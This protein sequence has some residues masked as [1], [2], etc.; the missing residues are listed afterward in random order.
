MSKGLEFDP[1]RHRYTLDGKPIPG[2]TTILGKGL[3]KPGLPYWSANVVA[4]Y[5][6]D[7]PGASYDELRRSPWAERD[8]A[9]VRGTEV[10]AYSEK[11][12]HGDEVDVPAT[13]APY[14][15]GAVD[16]MDDLG[17]EPIHTEVQLA[18]RAHW[19]AGTADLFARV[20]DE[21]VLLDW[22]TSKSV[23]GDYALQLAAYARADFLLVDGQEV[24]VPHVDR[25]GVI[26]L[27]PDGATPYWG[28]P[29]SDAFRMFLAVKTVSDIIKDI[30]RYFK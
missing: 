23:H 13:L 28:P 21:T 18:S 14:V 2:V 26:H 6:Q 25:I 1:G 27:T 12:L 30:E 3:P 19:Y 9:A 22:K 17:V 24:P 8:R 11:V 20:G 15:Q 4:Q 5:A 16:L 29:I 7:H 10:H